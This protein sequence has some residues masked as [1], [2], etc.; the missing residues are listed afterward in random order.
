M[1]A[2]FRQLAL[3]KGLTA[4]A[5]PIANKLILPP[6]KPGYRPQASDTSIETDNFEFALLRQRSNSDR[7]QMSAILTQGARQL[8][9]CGLRQTHSSL[10]ETEFASAIARAFLGEN[11]PDEFTP[12]GNEM[13]ERLR[14]V[15]DMTSNEYLRIN[16]SLIT[17][18][19]SLKNSP[20]TK[21]QSPL[22]I[23]LALVRVLHHL[24]FETEAC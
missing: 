16:S 3:T 23:K 19:R 9:L 5:K 13:T 18:N 24:N 2:R 20:V 7:L 4:T 6:V 15:Q 21:P 14:K 22:P 17:G 8:C 12:T 10:S 1:Q 11:Y